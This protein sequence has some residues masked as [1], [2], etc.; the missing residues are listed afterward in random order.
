MQKSRALNTRDAKA[1]ANG[2]TRVHEM[3][4]SGKEID[5]T[6]H[7]TTLSFLNLKFNS[8]FYCFG[9]FNVFGWLLPLNCFSNL[10]VPLLCFVSSTFFLLLFLISASS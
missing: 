9:V 5:I 3:R 1:N 6:K 2:L 4:S 7:L 10:T 8:Y